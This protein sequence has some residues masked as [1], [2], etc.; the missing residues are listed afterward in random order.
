[1]DSLSVAAGL[2]F[3]PLSTPLLDPSLLVSTPSLDLFSDFLSSPYRTREDV[4]TW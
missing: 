3:Y 1:M 2:N 4:E